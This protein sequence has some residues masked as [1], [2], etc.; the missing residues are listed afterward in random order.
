M[1][2]SNKVIEALCHQGT[3]NLTVYSNNCGIDDWGLGLLL[4]NKQI[5][6]MV[7]SYVGENKIF[8]NNIYQER[9]EV[10]LVPQGT[11]AERMRAG[12]SGIPG[13]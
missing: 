12:G 2:H 6:K 11:L 9:L 3:K 1:R 8:D 7:S 4:R 5:K 13:F 10:E